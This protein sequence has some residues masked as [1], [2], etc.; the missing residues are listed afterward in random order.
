[1]RFAIL[2]VWL[3]ACLAAC[4]GGAPPAGGPPSP[5]AT[6]ARSMPAPTRSASPAPPTVERPATWPPALQDF[7]P[8]G[9]RVVDAS[10]VDTDGD[11]LSELLVIY[12]DGGS[13]RGLVIR[14]EGPTGR[15]YPLGADKPVEL[16]RDSWTGNTV[17]DINADGK[18]EIM[19][20]GV[21]KGS[22]TTV[23]VFQWNGSAYV[24]LLSLTGT[25]GVAIDDPQARDVFDFTALQLLFERSAIMRA[26]HAEWKDNA[27]ALGSDVLFLLGPPDRTNYPEEAVLAYYTYLG[28]DEPE[29]M[30]ALLAEPLKSKTT[31]K[32]LQD[33]SRSVDEVSVAAL[34]VDDEKGDSAQVTADVVLTEHD[35]GKAQSAQQVWR[36]VKANGQWWLAERLDNNP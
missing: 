18:T 17:R 3:G 13:G 22:A 7:V 26:T 10:E 11:G 35:G 15:A 9:A 21:V 19:V 23:S 24:T 33:L 8:S 34:R 16:F 30:A 29:Q 6:A 2:C 12:S 28:K 32:A 5:T 25:Q 1:M 36:V 14:R 20:E 4:G 31:L 27:Y